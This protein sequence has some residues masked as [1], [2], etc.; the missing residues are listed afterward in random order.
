MKKQI[1]ERIRRARL[2]SDLSQENIA[3]ELGI[4]PGAYSNIET[5]KTDITVVRLFEIAEVLKLN[6]L[7]LLF[8]KTYGSVLA[9]KPTSYKKETSEIEQ[10]KSEM[11]KM[12]SE[13]DVLKRKTTPVPY[14]KLKKK[15]K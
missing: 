10:L 11:G 6:I 3:S 8:D 12:R 2:L 14:K 15:N 5:G 1:A 9:E 13:L 7:E 4:S